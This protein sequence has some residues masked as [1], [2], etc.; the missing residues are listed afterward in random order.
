MTSRMQGIGRIM[1]TDQVSTSLHYTKKAKSAGRYLQM[2]VA[3][4][5]L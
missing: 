3:P 1:P 5:L 4:R 2:E